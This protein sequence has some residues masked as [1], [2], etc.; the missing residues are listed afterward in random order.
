MSFNTK[1]DKLRKD[2]SEFD[3][4]I[5][6]NIHNLTHIYIRGTDFIFNTRYRFRIRGTDYT[7]YCIGAFN[8]FQ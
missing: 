3:T 5:R 7:F 6:G 8:L 2:V 1:K 4:A